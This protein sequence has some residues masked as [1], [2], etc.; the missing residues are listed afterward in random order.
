M[1]KK[2]KAAVAGKDVENLDGNDDRRVRMKIN[3]YEDVAGSDD[4]FMINRDKILLGERPDVARAKRYKEQGGWTL[5]T[6]I[7]KS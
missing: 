1:A 5:H 4:E 6:C 3:S 2:R 7:D